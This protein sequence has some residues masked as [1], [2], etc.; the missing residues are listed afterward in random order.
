MYNMIF[1]DE[2]C[3]YVNKLTEQ[4]EQGKI[5]RQAVLESIAFAREVAEEDAD[6]LSLIDGVYTKIKNMSEDEWNEIKRLLPFQVSI[7]A[8]DETGEVPEDEEA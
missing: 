8:E 5:T 2:E 3:Q 4:M 6:I 7:T 1:D